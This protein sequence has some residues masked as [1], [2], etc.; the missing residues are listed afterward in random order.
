MK[1]LRKTYDYVLY[2]SET[3]YAFFT[4]FLVSFL[5]SIFF[6][7]PTEI[8]MIPMILA[9]PKRAW[10]ISSF[11]LMASVLGGLAGYYVGAVLFDTV[12]IK[13]LEV[14]HYQDMFEQF[15][16]LYMKWDYW[17]VFAGGLTPFPY[18]VICIASGVVGMNVPL[19]VI[20]SAISRALRYYF[21][22]FLL[23]KYGD[24]ARGFIEKNLEVLTIVAF[25]LL[26][27]VVYFVKMM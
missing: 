24:D 20:A 19:F 6:P 8:I 5:G 13:I 21:I 3:K 1:I 25:V 10:W 2:L 18:K 17:I 16:N 9:K 14:L 22:A 7:F 27:M 11:A 4:L 23:R 26:F 15:K 12:G